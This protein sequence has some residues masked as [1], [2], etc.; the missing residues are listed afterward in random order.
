MFTNFLKE[1]KMNKFR[2]GISTS[3]ALKKYPLPAQW[4]NVIHSEFELDSCELVLDL[5]DPLLREPT[6]TAYIQDM[7][8]LA[9]DLQLE[10]HSCSIGKNKYSQS[11]L[12]HPNFG[13]RVDSLI[14][15]EKAIDVAAYTNSAIFG[16]YFGSI[17]DSNNVKPENVDYKVSFIKD[18]MSYIGSIAYSS[19]LSGLFF[20]PFTFYHETTQDF[21]INSTILAHLQ[22]Q[23]SIQVHLRPKHEI[24]H[25]YPLIN[26]QLASFYIQ[27]VEDVRVIQS[28][29][30]SGPNL[31]LKLILDTSTEQSI[32]EIK[33][34][35]TEIKQELK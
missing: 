20:E 28:H 23:C 33:Q 9:D 11:M 31:E 22:S 6:K 7:L 34:K 27:N 24:S 17:L 1:H 30:Q 15:Y 26:P 16:G 12:L 3:F 10:V 5:I 25:W 21:E 13:Y 29:L 8:E 2:L 32:Q 35:I 4:M 14:W 19:G 18:V